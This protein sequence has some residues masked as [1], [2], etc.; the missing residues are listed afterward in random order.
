MYRQSLYFVSPDSIDKR[1]RIS[2]ECDFRYFV[3]KSK[4]HTCIVHARTDFVAVTE[5]NRESLKAN[6]RCISFT[7][8]VVGACFPLLPHSIA[9]GPD[10]SLSFCSDNQRQEGL[11]FQREAAE[12]APRAIHLFGTFF[13]KKSLERREI[14][15]LWKNKYTLISHTTLLR[16]IEHTWRNKNYS[17][18]R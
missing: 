11:K 8:S 4:S 9:Y 2:F 10:S 18:L 13:E 7:M 16:L 15:S 14:S 3:R 6:P 17:H 12:N 1:T 5:T